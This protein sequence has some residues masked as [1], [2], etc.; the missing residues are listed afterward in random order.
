MAEFDTSMTSGVSEGEMA[1]FD[2]SMTSGV[3]E[4]E[5]EQL[6]VDALETCQSEFSAEDS[7][8]FTK[9][10]KK[11]KLFGVML[12]SDSDGEKSEKVPDAKRATLGDDG[13]EEDKTEAFEAGVD[14]GSATKDDTSTSPAVKWENLLHLVKHHFNNTGVG[15]VDIYGTANAN[16]DPTNV[17]NFVRTELLA[18]FAAI[19]H[20]HPTTAKQIGQLW[21]ERPLSNSSRK[22]RSWS[23]YLKMFFDADKKQLGRHCKW[24]KYYFSEDARRRW[25]STFNVDFDTPHEEEAKKYVAYSQILK[26]DAVTDASSRLYKDT[27]KAH[28]CKPGLPHMMNI[29]HVA[30]VKQQHRA[31]QDLNKGKKAA[32]RSAMPEGLKESLE[33]LALGHDSRYAEPMLVSGLCMLWFDVNGSGYWGKVRCCH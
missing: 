7:E 22:V 5:T 23:F 17:L 2:T 18:A 29:R 33:E 25:S 32:E 19:F 28:R 4:G 12:D 10:A 11:R 26:G 13:G 15:A 3:S 21:E 9:H 24:S 16:V 31:W 8:L 14:A 6:S 27:S 30:G 20:R 1:E